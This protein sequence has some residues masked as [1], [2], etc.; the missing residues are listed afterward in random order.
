MIL[1]KWATGVN[2]KYKILWCVS[3]T[4]EY[5]S[6]TIL[7]IGCTDARAIHNACEAEIMRFLK[8]SD[9]TLSN[10]CATILIKYVDTAIEQG[11]TAVMRML[12]FTTQLKAF[13]A[14]SEGYTIFWLYQKLVKEFLSMKVE[15]QLLMQLLDIEAD[16]Y[17]YPV[18]NATNRK[19]NLVMSLA[20]LSAFATRKG[21]TYAL[22]FE[23]CIERDMYK[24]DVPLDN[25]EDFVQRLNDACIQHRWEL[26]DGV[27]QVCTDIT[28][29]P[30]Y[31][32]NTMYDYIPLY[33]AIS[34][35]PQ[36]VKKIEQKTGELV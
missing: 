10:E 22:I 17:G 6:C 8:I 26:F 12:T 7:H 2:S 3:K 15:W 16:R 34:D 35:L 19:Y 31:A 28:F 14:K 33:V 13:V 23:Q 9:G 27:F 29:G 24:I 11:Y 5:V 20:E 21:H 30:A 25:R 18:N 32:S 1:L 36:S 4:L